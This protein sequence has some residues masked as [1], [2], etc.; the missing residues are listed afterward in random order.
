[1]N[2]V[3]WW[4]ELSAKADDAKKQRQMQTGARKLG[5]SADWERAR[6]EHKRKMSE[7]NKTS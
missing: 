5:S 2:I 3:D 1:M 7:R 4:W 6:A